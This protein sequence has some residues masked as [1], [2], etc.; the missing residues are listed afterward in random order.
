LLVFLTIALVGG[1]AVTGLLTTSKTIGST[2]SVKAINVEIY[3]D[4]E[5]TQV[6]TEIDWG[7]LESGDTATNTVYVK[8]TGNSAMTLSMYY[9]GWDPAEAGSYITLSWDREGATIDPDAVVEA[10][11]T[12]SVSAS[13]SGITTFSFNI[14]IE[15]TG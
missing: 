14:V 10:T 6:V 7:A 3:W 5:C 15:G 9:S 4:I 11:L 1:V 2:G 8:N 12:L 13:I